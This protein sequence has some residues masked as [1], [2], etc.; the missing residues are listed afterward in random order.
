MSKQEGEGFAPFTQQMIDEAGKGSKI[1]VDHDLLTVRE[2]G[3]KF[4]AMRTRTRHVSPQGQPAKV[5]PK[6]TRKG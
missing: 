3:G 5:M 4:Y 6:R 2:F 1:Q